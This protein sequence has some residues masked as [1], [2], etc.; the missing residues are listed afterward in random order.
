MGTQS[1]RGTALVVGVTGGVGCRVVRRLVAGDVSGPFVEAAAWTEGGY[2]PVLAEEYASVTVEQ[3]LPTGFSPLLTYLFGEGP[4][5][6]DGHEA[7]GV[8]NVGP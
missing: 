7:S 3:D 8:W 1:A 5:G 6:H 4:N 2:V